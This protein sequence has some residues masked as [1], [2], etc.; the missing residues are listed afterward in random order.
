[1]GFGSRPTAFSLKWNLGDDS[2]TKHT[3][4]Q[5]LSNLCCDS[6]SCQCLVQFGGIDTYIP[7]KKN[8]CQFPRII[9]HSVIIQDPTCFCAWFCL[10]LIK[11]IFPRKKGKATVKIKTSRH[12]AQILV[13]EFL[14]FVQPCRTQIELTVRYNLNLQILNPKQTLEEPGFEPGTF[15]MRSGHSTTELHPLLCS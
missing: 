1:M 9:I 7:I 6:C 4:T 12:V 5:K 15:H 14:C 13:T 2:K 3:L 10:Q 8:P 11:I